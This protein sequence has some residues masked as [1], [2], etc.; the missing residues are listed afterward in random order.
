MYKKL[1]NYKIWL[2]EIKEDLNKCKETPCS[3]V[4]RLNIVKMSVLPKL[5]DPR[6]AK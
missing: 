6:Q 4:R 1:K 3:Q 5:I 2:R